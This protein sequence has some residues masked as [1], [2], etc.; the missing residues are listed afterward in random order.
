M[1]SIALVCLMLLSTSNLFATI[2]VANCDLNL[3]VR[4][5]KLMQKPLVSKTKIK[6]D[7]KDG[8]TG[9]RHQFDLTGTQIRC[10]AAFSGRNSGTY[11]NCWPPNQEFGLQADRSSFKGKGQS[12]VPNVLTY[13]N[14]TA[15]VNIQLVCN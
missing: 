8:L 12:A 1:Y 7:S 11:I 2:E 3:K 5:T 9:N 10:E 6:L 15:S 13:A 14:K 4:T